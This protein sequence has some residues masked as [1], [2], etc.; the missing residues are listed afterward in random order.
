[1]AKDMT[2]GS[3]AKLL[4]DF[5]V[6]MM[7]GNI[8][9]QLYNLVDTLI[10]GRCLG[11]KEL[12]AVGATGNIISF[13]VSLI[14]G[15]SIGAGI[16]IAQYY[17]AGN[18]NK[19]KKAIVSIVYIITALTLLISVAGV[20]FAPAILHILQ[21]PKEIFSDALLYLRICISLIFG[22]TVYNGAAA[23]LRSI[24]DSSTPFIAVLVSSTIHVILNLIF[25]LVFHMGVA[26]VAL[27]TVISQAISAL[28]CIRHI[29]RCQRELSL[30]N[31]EWKPDQEMIRTI[32]RIGAPN[33]LQSSLIAVGGM[34]VQGLVNSFG[35]DTM[36][37]YTTVLRIDS[38]SIQ[39]VVGLATALS[40]FT[41]QNIGS[42]NFD[43]IKKAL[44]QTLAMMMVS[45][46][47]LAL[48][49]VIF[50]RQL[51]SLFLDPVTAAASIDIGC[52]Y[53]TIIGIAY[54]IAGVMN[55]YLNVIRGAGDVNVALI[56]GI[57]EVCGRIFFAYLLVGK[58]GTTGIWIATPLSWGC[59][60]LIPVLR[61]YTGK[62]KRM[63]LV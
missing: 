37:A 12:A 19:M 49:V 2:K 46:F 57:A 42:G 43:R 48:L 7:L 39:V 15:L 50:R 51:L 25:V 29:A 59:G 41:G 34:S 17:G 45:S 30:E 61:Y 13:M 24:G 22:M 28:I 55:S 20:L 11:T 6:P 56:A 40:V 16:V 52:T 18:F 23:I 3:S 1:M 58:F 33:A 9:Q 10:V 62:W 8:F 60:C 32:I 27:G 26:G 35:T 4:I 63:N 14:F 21:V 53:M 36:A 38:V 31:I 5:A 54:V 47:C 44:H